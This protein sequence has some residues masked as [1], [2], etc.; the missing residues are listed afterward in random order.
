MTQIRAILF[1]LRA[2]IVLVAV[3]AVFGGALLTTPA[4]RAAS[5]SPGVSAPCDHH[6]AMDGKPG[7]PVKR[8]GYAG[9]C[10]DCCLFGGL[11]VLAL[12]Q[13]RASFLIQ[14]PVETGSQAL[15]YVIGANAPEL[16]LY[17]SANGARA[18][19]VAI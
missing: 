16:L 11:G 13:A 5:L 9:H 6:P 18:P 17:R 4:A 14:P 12:Q 15:Y 2:A 7:A 3:A 19:P 10:P 8:A 1:R